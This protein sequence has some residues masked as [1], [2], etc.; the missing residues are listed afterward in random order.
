MFIDADR[1]KRRIQR[2]VHPTTGV[3]VWLKL[4]I[5]RRA[6]V[7]PYSTYVRQAKPN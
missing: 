4:T 3:S 7:S 6:A 1:F 5:E 2:I